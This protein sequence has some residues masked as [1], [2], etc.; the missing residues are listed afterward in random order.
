MVVRLLIL[1]VRVPPGARTFVLS[2]VCRQ[3]E[4]SASG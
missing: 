4:V 2:D 1:W 3:V